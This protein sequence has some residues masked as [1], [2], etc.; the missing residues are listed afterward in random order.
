M[1]IFTTLSVVIWFYGHSGDFCHTYL[2]FYY[3]C[4]D[5]RHTEYGNNSHTID[6]HTVLW[7]VLCTIV[8]FTTQCSENRHTDIAN[9]STLIHI[10]K[11]IHGVAI[12]TIL[13]DSNYYPPYGEFKLIC[14][15]KFSRRIWVNFTQQYGKNRQRCQQNKFYYAIWQLLL[16]YY[17][18]FPFKILFVYKVGK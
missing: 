11:L 3:A 16:Y 1:A 5:I 12:S 15:G 6:F 9:F 13:C 4:G 10:Q 18:E 17:R 2:C 14:T 8:N 7:F